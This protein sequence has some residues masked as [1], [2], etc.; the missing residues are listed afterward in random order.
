M[1]HVYV[2]GLFASVVPHVAYPAT[3]LFSRIQI[4]VYDMQL[5]SQHGRGCSGRVPVE[6]AVGVWLPSVQQIDTPV[7]AGMK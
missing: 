5:P 6:M 4:N 7:I 3:N 1:L 2:A